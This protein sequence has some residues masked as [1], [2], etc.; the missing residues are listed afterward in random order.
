MN[1]PHMCKFNPQL[2]LFSYEKNIICLSNINFFMTLES[3]RSIHKN[4]TRPPI[5]MEK[6]EWHKI[7]D[8]SCLS[9]PLCQKKQ[10]VI[11]VLVQKNTIQKLYC[12]PSFYNVLKHSLI[13]LYMV[14]C[15]KLRHQKCYKNSKYKSHHKM[16]GSI[17]SKM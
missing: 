5:K 1:N 13:G 6:M 16:K 15:H 2:D 14:L 9:C 10:I 4:L 3:I 12:F 17:I 7:A 11:F 8:S